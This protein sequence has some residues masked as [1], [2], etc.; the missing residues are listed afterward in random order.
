M[1]IETNLSLSGLPENIQSHT[2]KVLQIL[3]LNEATDISKISD[4]FTNQFWPHIQSVR[5]TFSSKLIT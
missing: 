3:S 5:I 2:C 4:F 1:E